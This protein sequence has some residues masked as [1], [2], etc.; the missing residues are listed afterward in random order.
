[1]L[2]WP[3]SLKENGT[4]TILPLRINRRNALDPFNNPKVS[5]RTPSAAHAF[6]YSALSYAGGVAHT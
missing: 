6:L 5:L 2:S 3:F 1:M 4:A